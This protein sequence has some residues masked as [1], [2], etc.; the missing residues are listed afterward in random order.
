[1]PGV[2]VV[3]KNAF[4]TC[5]AL[6]YIECG[7]LE[8]IR[9]QAFQYC[10]SL[11]SINLPSAKIVEGDAFNYCT[12]LT[13]V[14]FGNK[15]ERIERMAFNKCPSLERITTPLKDGLITHDYIFTG[16]DNLKRVDLVEGEVHETIAALQL[17]EWRN[18]MNEEINSINHILPDTP[19]G[20]GRD[21][22]GENARAIGTWIRS[23][24]RK[25]IRYRA[26][27]QRY[28]NEA[29]TTLQL[30]LALPQDIVIN[31]IFPFLE[32]APY[33]FLQTVQTQS[34]P[35]YHR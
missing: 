32:L 13:N 1:M 14:K 5:K 31:N 25:I 9:C 22:K 21:D 33:P 35:S 19:V 18:D 3:E 30:Q 10:N 4:I 12:A 15:L 34:F 8:I 17:E 7:K 16:C 28:L 27:H 6:T 24:L 29:A 26:K 11:G 2:E 23:V 20:S